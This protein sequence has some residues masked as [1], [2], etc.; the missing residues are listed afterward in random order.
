M[1]LT[2]GKLSHHLIFHSLDL[3]NIKA[4]SILSIYVVLRLIWYSK[5]STKNCTYRFVVSWDYFISD[6][7]V[8]TVL[9]PQ[10][11]SLAP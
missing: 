4:K 5:K 9:P 7:V 2:L 1:V 10:S 8:P 11:R 3:A 6:K